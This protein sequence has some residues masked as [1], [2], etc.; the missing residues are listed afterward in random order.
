MMKQSPND[1]TLILVTPVWNDSRRLAGFGG[2]LA[3]ALAA[4]GGEIHWVVADDGTGS[5]EHSRLR[6]LVAIFGRE[7]PRITL[8][9]AGTHR[10]KGAV[11]R[12]AWGLHP[13]AV[14]YAF[15]DADGSVSA[16]DMLDLIDSARES[17]QTTI[18]VR[19]TTDR[20][21]VEEGWIRGIRHRGFLIAVRLLLGFRTEDTQ[22]GAK[23]VHGDSY[24]KIEARL[25]EP[26]WAFD[27]ELLAE[28]HASGMPWREQ[29]V[30]WVEKGASR[31]RPWMDSF[32]MLLSLVKIRGRLGPD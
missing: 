23:V 5:A 24:R 4:R 26:G 9:L 16:R 8:H 29:P 28:F 2:E 10:G 6:E 1:A 20:T 17:G 11:I 22:C 14:W 7:C 32:R 27:A 15:V 19:K 18:G 31:I 21:R 13:D 25:I 3:S 30:N 12:E